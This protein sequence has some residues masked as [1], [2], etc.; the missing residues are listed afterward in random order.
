MQRNVTS[1]PGGG[2]PGLIGR[3]IGT[4]FLSIVVLAG[5][6]FALLLVIG[7]FQP[8]QQRWVAWIALFPLFFAVAGV[9]GIRSLWRGRRTGT[10]SGPDP[11]RSLSRLADAA[12]KEHRTGAR[13]GGCVF[14]IFFLAGA[15]MFIV[16]FV[17]PVMRIADARGWIETP[18][19]ILSSAVVSHESHSS[20]GSGTTYSIDVTYE[21]AR[22]GRTYTSNRYGFSTGSSSGHDWR[23][24]IVDRLP[25]G[26]KSICFVN[27]RDPADAVLERGF[28]PDLWFGLFPLAFLLVG[29][30]GLFFVLRSRGKS[31]A[32]ASTA[33]VGDRSRPARVETRDDDEE[34]DGDARGPVTLKPDASPMGK[35][36]AVLVF[37]LFWNGI[38]SIFVVQAVGGWMRGEREWFLTIFLIPFVLI[39]LVAL[40]IAVYQFLALFNPRPTLVVSARSVP[41]G[42]SID[43][44][45]KLSGDARK[46]KRFRIVLEGRE[47]A[48]YRRGTSTYTDKSVFATI[49]VVEVRTAWDIRTGRAA[50]TVPADTMHS[51]ASDNNTIVWHLRAQGEVPL[52]P[53]INDEYVFEVRPL[54]AGP[55]RAP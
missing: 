38:V 10:G 44:Q 52:W 40:G 24:A 48:R 49:T 3:I 7:A 30:G 45:W 2:V 47:T 18:C 23:Q 11:S 51:F 36:I 31:R 4:V 12:A 55:G 1:D 15:A 54:P 9:L 32:G 41:L 28:T 20:R 21:Y 42:G 37:A 33:A 16:L 34:D 26:S 17:R 39:G 43:V 19:V 5:A 13:V 22:D 50:V 8:G 35:L 46:L 27:P 29:A 53:D 6:V 25:P 14:L